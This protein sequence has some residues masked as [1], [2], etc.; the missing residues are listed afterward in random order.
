MFIC[1]VASHHLTSPLEHP[2]R[3][4]DQ[5]NNKRG[6]EFQIPNLTSPNGGKAKTTFSEQMDDNSRYLKKLQD[7]MM[8]QVDKVNNET[9][10]QQ[11]MDDDLI[12]KSVQYPYKIPHDELEKI[13]P[14]LLKQKH[15]P[16]VSLH[17]INVISNSLKENL[18][19]PNRL[20]SSHRD[21]IG[22]MNMA[23]NMEHLKTLMKHMANDVLT[24]NQAIR[25]HTHKK[26]KQTPVSG[27]QKA[28]RRFFGVAMKLPQ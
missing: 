8:R 1:L 2:N 27:K 12:N 7:D 9:I 20:G 10:E 18:K 16:S 13:F 26:Q 24:A 5:N 15:A 25:N 11:A 14:N 28:A 22:N 23:G 4:I 17:S 6:F 3:N 21:L 19:D